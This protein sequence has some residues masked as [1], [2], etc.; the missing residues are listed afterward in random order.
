M[1]PNIKT[2][3][4]LKKNPELTKRLAKQLGI[5]PAALRQAILADGRRQMRDR[6][7]A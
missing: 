6:K 4:G 1:N 5:T 3:V 7:G 2:L